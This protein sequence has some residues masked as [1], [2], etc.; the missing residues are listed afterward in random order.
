MNLLRI[1]LRPEVNVVWNWRLQTN[2]KRSRMTHSVIDQIDNKHYTTPKDKR[3]NKNK[4]QNQQIIKDR[5][6]MTKS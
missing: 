2:K 6:N 3:R 4:E 1:D 5:K